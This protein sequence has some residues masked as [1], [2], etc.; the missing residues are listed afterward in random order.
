MIEVDEVDAT[1]PEMI[2]L[3]SLIDHGLTT[4]AARSLIEAAEVSDLLLDIRSAASA[5]E[6]ACRGS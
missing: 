6:G 4:C 5:A 2:L 3:F 1:T